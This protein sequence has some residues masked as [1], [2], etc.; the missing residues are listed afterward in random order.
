MKRR[1]DR[2]S[3][4]RGMAKRLKRALAMG[5]AINAHA[6]RAGLVKG[7]CGPIKGLA[8]ASSGGTPDSDKHATATDK[9]TK[10]LQNLLEER[11][12]ATRVAHRLLVAHHAA[13]TLRDNAAAA[14]GYGQPG[15]VPDALKNQNPPFAAACVSPGE[16]PPLSLSQLHNLTGLQNLQALHHMQA[17][18]AL[19]KMQSL[20][21]LGGVPPPISL[22]SLQG[23]AQGIPLEGLDGLDAAAGLDRNAAG[24][25]GGV[26]TNVDAGT[27]LA[28]GDE[29]EYDSDD[30]EDDEI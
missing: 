13:T 20:Q 8:V 3:E 12:T 2:Q 15:R 27:N 17:L 11:Q 14:N 7:P 9:G 25:S 4:K 10:S 30:D 26:A 28:E 22:Q 29:S 24:V 6:R 21:S 5:D 23:L 16:D 19:Q 18:Q 1:R